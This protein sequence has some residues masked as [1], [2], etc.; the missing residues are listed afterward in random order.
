MSAYTEG[1]FTSE[2][3]TNVNKRKGILEY[4]IKKAKIHVQ[5]AK[6]F[7]KPP[8][9][10]IVREL[11]VKAY[12]MM[13]NEL[14]LQAVNVKTKEEQ[15]GSVQTPLEKSVRIEIST[16]RKHSKMFKLMQDIETLRD[17]HEDEA[18]EFDILDEKVLLLEREL[19]I[20]KEQF[21]IQLRN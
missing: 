1:S 21:Y 8:I 7:E 18:V 10:V 2:F 5:K 4:K 15:F 9:K 20:L 19:R 3:I 14:D 16:V 6:K 11:I 17:V 13:M 12:E